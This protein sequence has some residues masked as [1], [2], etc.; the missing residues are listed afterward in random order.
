MKLRTEIM[1]CLEQHLRAK[2]WTQRE[3]ATRLHVSQPRISKLMSGVSEDFSLDMLVKLA[4]RA[5]LRTSLKIA[6]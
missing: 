4:H 1:I 2:N 3:A 5:G 6:A